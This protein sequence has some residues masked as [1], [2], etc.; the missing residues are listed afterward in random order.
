[1]TSEQP[2]AALLMV[3]ICQILEEVHR[4]CRLLEQQRIQ[5]AFRKYHVHHMVYIMFNTCEASAYLDPVEQRRFC[6]WLHT[7]WAKITGR[8][9][10]GHRGIGSQFLAEAQDFPPPRSI[11]TSYMTHLP[12]YSVGTKSFFPWGAKQARA[13]SWPVIL[14]PRLRMCG[15]KPYWH[16]K[17]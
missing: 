17:E 2:F 15:F 4:P 12:F 13:W 10:A 8:S 1:M 5:L 11:Q 9:W 7:Y 14:L 3:S 16:C 6:T